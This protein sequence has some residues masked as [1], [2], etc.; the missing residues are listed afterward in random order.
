[1]EM[2]YENKE[3]GLMVAENED[4]QMW[5]DVKKDTEQDIIKLKK[6]LKFQEAVLSL[7]ASKIVVS[8]EKS[9]E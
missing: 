8:P 4:E 3:L 7:A 1:M 9:S 2:V 5:I 6:M